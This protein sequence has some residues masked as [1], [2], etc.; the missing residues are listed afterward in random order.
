MSLLNLNHL[1]NKYSLDVK[2]IA[3]IGAHKG[4]EVEDYK[5]NFKNVKIYLFEPQLNLFE[6]LKLNFGKDSNISLFNFA[7]GSS[8]K[9]SSMYMADNEGQSSSF[10]KPKHHL[11]EHPEIKFLEKKLTFEI[12]VLDELGITD[13]DLL[14]IDTQGFELEVLKGSV[15]ILSKDVKY[16]I[17]EVNKKEVYEGCP[18]VRDIDIF[19]KQYG[20]I[21]TDTQYWDGSYSW[22][23]AFYIKKEL[24]SFKHYLFSILKNF[25]YSFNFSYKF[26]IYLR[27]IIWKIRNNNG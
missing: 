11:I 10:L 23:D 17:L 26:F 6:Y 15:N 16:I 24:V 2:Q 21:R 7:L 27:N 20:F 9:I 22:G 18:H 1:K 13:I 3:H 5:K 25:L 8:N 12:K 14:N 4:Q 19:L